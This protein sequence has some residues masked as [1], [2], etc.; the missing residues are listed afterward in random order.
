MDQM[1]RDQFSTHTLAEPPDEVD[2]F[3]AKTETTLKQIMALE[4]DDKW[5]LIK[6]YFRAR[7][8][9]RKTELDAAVAARIDNAMIGEK[10]AVFSEV[11]AEFNA[12]ETWIEKNAQ[13]VKKRDERRKA[14]K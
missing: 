7:I 3:D 5:D 14:K 12:F 1:P 11:E 10:Y 13:E 6:K 4:A 8:G 9:I 2:E